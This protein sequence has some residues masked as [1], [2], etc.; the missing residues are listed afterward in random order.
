[1]QIIKQIIASKSCILYIFVS[2]PFLRFY[3][4]HYFNILL[5]I[6]LFISY[7]IVLAFPGGSEVKVSASNAGNLGS[8]PGSGK[9]PGEGNGNPLQYSCLENPMDGGAW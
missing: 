1:M 3:I 8:I 4:L 9:S 6:F 5:D 2:L 7:I